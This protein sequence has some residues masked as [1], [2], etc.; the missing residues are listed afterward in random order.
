M[1]FRNFQSFFFDFMFWFQKED[2]FDFFYDFFA[3]F[4]DLFAFFYDLFEV[5][6]YEFYENNG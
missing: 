3:F 5:F 1:R 6:H 2:F 4:Y